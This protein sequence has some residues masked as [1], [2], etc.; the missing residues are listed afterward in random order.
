LV[1]RTD[2]ARPCDVCLPLSET[3]KR[4]TRLHL[5]AES[6]RSCVRLRGRGELATYPVQLGALV[7]GGTD[8]RLSRRVRQPATCM[9]HLGRRILPSTVEDEDLCPVDEAVATKQREVGLIPTPPAQRA[10]PFGG[11]SWLVALMTGDDDGA[12]H[13]SRQDRRN[14]AFGD[15]HHDL[16]EFRQP[17]RNLAH[18][19]LGLSDA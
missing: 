3:E 7:D 6:T 1:E 4:Q 10:R 17:R 19:D 15:R 14:L 12:V 5:M 13:D 9:I 8:R 18:R 11:S 2:K 16:V